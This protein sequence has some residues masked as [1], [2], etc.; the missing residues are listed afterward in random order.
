MNALPNIAIQQPDAHGCSPRLLIARVGQ[1]SGDPATMKVPAVLEPSVMHGNPVISRRRF[2]VA[3]LAALA[4]PQ[5]GAAQLTARVGFLSPFTASV[6]APWHEAFRHGLR[7]LG[8]TE[9]QNIT[10]EYRYANG[11]NDRLPKLAAELVRLKVD[12]IVVS[13]GTDRRS[14]KASQRRFPS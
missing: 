12:V 9:G 3:L 1:T 14:P 10:I 4:L 6:A 2:V 13:V 11:N 7:E 8:W 5:A